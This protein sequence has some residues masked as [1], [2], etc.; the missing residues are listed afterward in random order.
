MGRPGWGCW[1]ARGH[2]T[3]VIAWSLPRD[4]RIAAANKGLAFV[5]TEDEGR[6]RESPAHA[7]AQRR[8]A[9]RLAGQPAD[10]RGDWIPGFSDVFLAL[11]FYSLG[12]HGRQTSLGPCMSRPLSATSKANDKVDQICTL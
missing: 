12:P 9:T 4:K 2:A 5:A 8:G 10:K 6:G 7:V 11:L 1:A 3:H